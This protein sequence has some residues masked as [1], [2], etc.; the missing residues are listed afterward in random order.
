[1]D[2]IQLNVSCPECISLPI[3]SANATK[4]PLSNYGSGFEIALLSE[5]IL[6]VSITSRPTVTGKDKSLQIGS[7]P[8]TRSMRVAVTRIRASTPAKPGPD[9]AT[10]T[11]PVLL[12]TRTLTPVSS[13]SSTHISKRFHLVEGSYE[14]RSETK[15]QW[16]S[17]TRCKKS[18]TKFEA[19]ITYWLTYD[20]RLKVLHKVEAFYESHATTINGLELDRAGSTSQNG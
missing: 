6:M 17:S 18:N 11:N 3:P 15:F 1:M 10:K 16:F 14:L 19:D 7:V 4:Q 20:H 13:H 8:H 12:D 5:G 9:D 2:G